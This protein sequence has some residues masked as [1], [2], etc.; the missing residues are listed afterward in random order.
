M[1]LRARLA[2]SEGVGKVIAGTGTEPDIT[3]FSASWNGEDGWEEGGTVPMQTTTKI[4]PVSHVVIASL[5]CRPH[6]PPSPPRGTTIAPAAHV[7]IFFT[8]TAVT[9]PLIPP[10]RVFLTQGL[11]SSALEPGTIQRPPAPHGRLPSLDIRDH[12]NRDSGSNLATV[13]A[14]RKFEGAVGVKRPS[15]S[16]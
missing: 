8:T 6:S 7:T 14:G 2:S 11:T 3:P 4:I 1:N 10:G 16:P 13:P 5:P 12:R 9:V 15:S